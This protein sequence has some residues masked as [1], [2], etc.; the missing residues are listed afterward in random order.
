MFNFNDLKCDKCGAKLETFD[1][2]SIT[3]TG[4][5]VCDYC[6]HHFILMKCGGCNGIFKNKNANYVWKGASTGKIYAKK[7]EHVGESLIK[8]HKCSDIKISREFHKYKIDPVPN[9][10]I[11][12]PPKKDHSE[13]LLSGNYEMVKKGERSKTQM[14]GK[15]YLQSLVIDYE[16]GT[17]L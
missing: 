3:R 2:L 15:R 9:D 7:P 1:D 6:D 17:P 13:D 8:C 5:F 12:V 14:R 11:F 4:T 16:E 10:A